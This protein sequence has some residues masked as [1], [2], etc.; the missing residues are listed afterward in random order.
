MAVN[1]I[2]MDTY[3]DA[4][5]GPAEMLKYTLFIFVPVHW[6]RIFF[7]HSEQGPGARWAVGDLLPG[8][9]LE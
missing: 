1:A 8:S 2:V 4:G 9:K 5:S 6:A 7:R 3:G